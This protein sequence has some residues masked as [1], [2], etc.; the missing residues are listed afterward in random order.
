[1]PSTVGF[2]PN[3]EHLELL[4]KEMKIERPS[5][6]EL[7]PMVV[8]PISLRTI[9]Q[10]PLGLLELGRGLVPGIHKTSVLNQW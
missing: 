5:D 3:L 10:G 7:D 9:S 1:M 8:L 6:N 4:L 2:S